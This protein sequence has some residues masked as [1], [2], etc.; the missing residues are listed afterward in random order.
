MFK[1][2]RKLVR[3][4]GQ[5]EPEWRANSIFQI[6]L[7]ET[8]N[9]FKPAEGQSSL[10]LVELNLAYNN[11]KTIPNT[12][13]KYLDNLQ[14]VMIQSITVTLLNNSKIN[15]LKSSSFILNKTG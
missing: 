13:F 9:I 6:L 14:K 12:A 5:E 10:P 2:G 3:T 1:I 4:P 7:H 15:F 8:E 11:I